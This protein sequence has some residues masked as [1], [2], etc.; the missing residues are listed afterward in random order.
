MKEDMK[1]QNHAPLKFCHS[2]E[3]RFR[4]FCETYGT[5]FYYRSSGLPESWPD[6][7]DIV[8]GTVDNEDLKED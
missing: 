4:G 6:I 3:D 2:S 8:L 5:M 7:M 1:S